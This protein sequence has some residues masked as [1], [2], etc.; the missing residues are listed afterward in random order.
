[1]K[2]KH[3]KTFEIGAEVTVRFRVTSQ[4]GTRVHLETIEADGAGH[5]AGFWA[6]PGQGELVAAKTE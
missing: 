2:D 4:S 3:G 6:E 1:M 5:K